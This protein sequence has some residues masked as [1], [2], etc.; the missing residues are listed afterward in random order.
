MTDQQELWNEETA[1]QY[2]TPGEGMF[3]PDVLG[4]T[5][6]VLSE[7]D[8]DHVNFPKAPAAIRAV[9][10]SVSARGDVEIPLPYGKVRVPSSTVLVHLLV[11]ATA[12]HTATPQGPGIATIA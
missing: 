5:V 10:D 1:Q 8:A 9:E 11:V 2:E 3:S 12:H 7:L 6:Q 4:P